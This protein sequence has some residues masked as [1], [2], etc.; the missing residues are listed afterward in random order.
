MAKLRDREKSRRWQ[1]HLRPDSRAAFGHEGPLLR[2]QL[3]L[4]A[5][6]ERS[7]KFSNPKSN[8]WRLVPDEAIQYSENAA[9]AGRE[10]QS[11]LRRVVDEHPATPWALLAQR[12]L[13][14]PLGFKWMETY[15]PPRPR[16]NDAE[17]AKRK[18]NMNQPK[19]P[20]IPKL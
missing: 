19:P 13:E 1:A 3:G 8:A 17:A 4:C 5:D 2:V 16:M 15:V 6:E 18:K 14:N 20:E 11:L 10:A 12:E 7:P 9:A